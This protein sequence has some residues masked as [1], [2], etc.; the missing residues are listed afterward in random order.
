[1][2]TIGNIFKLGG[3]AVVGALFSLASCSD[4]DDHYEASNLGGTSNKTAWE[5]LQQNPDYSDFCEVLQK[6]RVF[7]QHKVTSATYAEMLQGGL[8][9][10]VFAPKNGTFKKQEILN[11]LDSV[12]GDSIVQK[13]FIFNHLSRNIVSCDGKEK[14]FFLANGKTMTLR[15]NTVG[16]DGFNF[17]DIATANV[18]IKNGVV[19][20]LNNQMPFARNVYEMLLDSIRYMGTGNELRKYMREKFQ[21]GQS[22]A[23]GMKDGEIIY[24]DS[25]MSE[26]N[27]F[28]DYVG[29]LNAEDS[30][31]YVTIPT[32]NAWKEEWERAKKYF[33]YDNTVEKSDSMQHFYTLRALLDDAIYSPSVQSSKEDS[34][35]NWKAYNRRFPEDG[36]CFKNPFREGG[37]MGPEEKMI[38]CTNG[39]IH[40]TDTWALTPTKTYFNVIR[41][42]GEDFHSICTNYLST[43]EK[44]TGF[45]PDVKYITSPT[46]SGHGL[47]EIAPLTAMAKWNAQFRVKNTLAGKYDVY[48]RTQPFKAVSPTA[49]EYQ[50]KYGVRIYTVDK[51]GKEVVKECGTFK[52][53]KSAPEEM[54]V[55][56]GYD[57]GYCNYGLTNDKVRIEIYCSMTAAESRTL[58]G[59]LLLD[60]IILRP[61]ESK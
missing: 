35:V 14:N 15:G 61:S 38:K 29:L 36:H 39:R 37:I 59:K 28:F 33:T 60:C 58:S 19:H 13:Q 12:K 3:L 31:Y 51:D 6:A 27:L 4:W 2:K 16:R 49:K 10:T 53:N 48:V 30:M 26:S 40:P 45:H 54:L 23:N 56:K 34:L 47:L 11:Q 42:Q 18:P 9:Y 7:R 46:I 8:S 43:D 20:F 57:F 17:V 55:E 22:L 1:M 52:S 24:V 32:T 41:V 5:V 50:S 21:P 25:V 44:K